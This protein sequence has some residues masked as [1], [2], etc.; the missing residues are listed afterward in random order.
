ML[1]RRTLLS[2]ALPALGA[3]AV[4]TTMLSPLL[5]GPGHAAEP[6]RTGDLAGA[7]TQVLTDEQTIL[8]DVAW[9]YDLGLLELMAVNQGVDP[10][11]PGAGR[12]ILLPTAH[13]LPR[14]PRQGVVI[15]KSELR[16]YHYG[17]DGLVATH[18]IGI[19]REGHSTPDG[20]TTIVRK[21]ENPT[22]YPTAA[23]R[24][25]RPELPAQ[26]G[27]GPDNPLG[28]R[29]MY[30]GWPTYLMHGTNKPYGVGRLVSR[31]CIRL[32]PQTAHLLF[33]RLP[34][35]TP[36]NVVEEPVKVGW[37]EEGLFIEVHP[38][39]D[40]L[41]ELEDTHRFTPGEPAPM[42]AARDLIA[43]RGAEPDA[44][45]WSRVEQELQARRGLPVQ[46]AGPAVPIS[47]GVQPVYAPARPEG[48]A[49]LAE[50]EPGDGNP[51]VI[52]PAALHNVY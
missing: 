32:Y 17:P 42:Q 49:L 21:R 41:V 7:L 50:E 6:A 24:Q 33:K 22:W 14:A 46:I 51:A 25:D 12:M 52:A 34:V 37:H 31:G 43:A 10:W 13:L 45:D 28:D 29:A 4:G 38:T 16:L 47:G 27:P 15:N 39:F 30:F 44:V 1:S 5:S 26:V 36:I 2:T 35:G 48:E 23:T 19:G 40:Q 8:L 3:A 20:R 9:Q 11:I 18:A